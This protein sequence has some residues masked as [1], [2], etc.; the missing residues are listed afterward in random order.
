MNHKHA[1]LALAA[2]AGLSILTFAPRS[3]A[4]EPVL[5]KEREVSGLAGKARDWF[6]AELEYL[7][8]DN[9]RELR[10]KGKAQSK[11]KAA[12][13]KEWESRSKKVDIL[14][15]VPD[16]KAIFATAF[17][18]ERESSSGELK[19]I[20]P[21]A[22]VVKVPEH[23]VV[24]PRRYDYEVAHRL[25]VL[26]TPRDTDGE[27]WI[28]P[29][30]H[31]DATWGS[32]SLREETIFAIPTVEDSFD[33]DTPLQADQA[34]AEDIER[35]R[36][37]AVI[38]SMRG[39]ADTYYLDFNKVF[40]DTGR[41]AS[42][43]AM[44]IAT[45]F[46]QSFAGIIIRNP[47]DITDEIR[48]GSLRGMPVL[49]I[50]SDAETKE[51]AE[52]IA[53]VLNGMQPDSATVLEGKGE[54]PFTASQPEIDRWMEGRSRD[55]TPH[56]VVVEPNHDGFRTAYWVVMGIAEPL[57]GLPNALRPRME[58][59]VDREKNRI[60]VDARNVE[61]FQLL[62]NDDLLD[63]GKEFTVV[64]NGKAIQEKRERNLLFMFD[65][66]MK[67]Q[68]PSYVFTTEFAASVPSADND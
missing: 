51:A 1:P 34:N 43:F 39:V 7:A 13:L 21:D 40:L 47:V 29:K 2:L 10:S 32:S 9:P 4:Q 53:S 36:I 58:V 65:K 62:L 16:V 37:K 54:S 52:K 42:A 15:S 19:L 18:H 66:M 45:F 60:V 41:G 6:E 50:H 11:A 20:K 48:L 5:L 59:K 24:V 49:L 63:L 8:A 14:S 46:P 35:D 3:A 12:F 22:D 64:V 68:D 56:H 44:R 67:R 28:R 61:D 27:S 38:G 30:D 26:L 17:P 55:L 33:F 25:V 31:F 57:A 23:Y